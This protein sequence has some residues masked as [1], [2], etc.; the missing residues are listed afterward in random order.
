M[1]GELDARLRKLHA[2]ILISYSVPL[3]VLIDAARIGAELE[4]E[5]CA[6]IALAAG[7][8]EVE[9]RIRDRGAP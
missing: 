3:H 4:R 5:A 8:E 7:D 6:A 2:E 9:M 1:P